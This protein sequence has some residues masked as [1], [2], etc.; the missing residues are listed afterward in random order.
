MINIYNEINTLEAT[1]RKTP[2][3]EALKEAVTVVKEDKEALNLFQSFRKVQMDLQNK[4]LTGEEILEDELIYA[5]KTAQ[6]A[7]QN[8]KISAMLEA[9]MNLS[10]IIEEVNR[11]LIKPIQVLYEEF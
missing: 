1:F 2:E 3:F 6:L 11:I 4:Q 5:Q 7:Q 9:E 8:A 10:K